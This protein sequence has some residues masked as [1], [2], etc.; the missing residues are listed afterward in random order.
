MTN[1]IDPPV[2]SDL[3]SDW[4]LRRRHGGDPG[5]ERIVR[6]RV[7]EYRDRVLDGARLA[8]GM[9]LLDVGAG[10]GLISFGALQRIGQPFF[11]ILADI[12]APMLAHA[13]HVSMEIG[14]RDRCSFVQTAAETLAGIADESV[15]A[16]TSRAVLA[17]VEDKTAAAR[18][19]LR[20]LKPGGRL[21][22]C[23]PIDLDAAVQ[24]AALTNFL[25]SE[26]ANPNTPYLAL[27]QRCRAL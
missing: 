21:S 23:E 3:W 12:S 24:L 27:L 20:V 15:D 16:L 17:Y 9:T 13:E 19:F 8:P 11:V 10:E 2:E 22:L 5:Y 4:L 6:S 26:P 1:H 25:R 18:N 14:V 7:L